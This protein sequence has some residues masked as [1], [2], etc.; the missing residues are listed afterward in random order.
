MHK[1]KITLDL[2][3]ESSKE[4]MVAQPASD[5]CIKF[6]HVYQCD[7]VLLKYMDTVLLVVDVSKKTVLDLFIHG[8]ETQR[9]SRCLARIVVSG[10]IAFW[11]SRAEDERES[12]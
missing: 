10:L 2:A 1:Q 12:E 4:Y 9:I 5:S 11:T 3:I 7:G 8:S 6:S